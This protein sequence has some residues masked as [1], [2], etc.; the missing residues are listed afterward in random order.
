MAADGRRPSLRNR[1]RAQLQIPLLTNAQERAFS[2]HSQ[3]HSRNVQ[4]NHATSKHAVVCFCVSGWSCVLP[5]ARREPAGH[6]QAVC[7]LRHT[8][9]EAAC[10]VFLMGLHRAAAAAGSLDEVKPARWL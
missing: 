6:T 5:K 2:G 7:H 9:E 3:N 10:R 4:R 8:C 1:E